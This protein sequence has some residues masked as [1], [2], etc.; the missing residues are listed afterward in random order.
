[1]VDGFIAMVAAL[2]AFR[3]DPRVRDYLFAS[4]CSQEPGYRRAAGELGLHPMLD[5]DM[6][7]GEGT[8]CPLA[9]RLID[10]ATRVCNEMGTFA[11]GSIDNSGFVDIREQP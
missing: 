5:M 11:Q 1:M 4:H 2:T 10:A 7:L 8:G 9:F 6:R 3:I